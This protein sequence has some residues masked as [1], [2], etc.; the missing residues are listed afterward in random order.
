MKN[1]EAQID[2]N[3][4]VDNTENVLEEIR[5]LTH[6]KIN[7]FEVVHK[8]ICEEKSTRFYINDK[9]CSRSQPEKT[10]IYLWL[11]TGFRD[12]H[13]CPIMI[14]LR[15]INGEYIG[16]YTG[17]IRSM[18]EGIRKRSTHNRHL[19]TE[20]L[21]Q[22]I[23]KYY[24]K[25]ERRINKFIQNENSYYVNCTN[26]GAAKGSLA[27]KIGSLGVV[28]EDVEEACA[29]EENIVAVEEA[30]SE[31]EKEITFGLLWDK[32]EDME[33][34]VAELLEIIANN[35][36][37]SSAKV[38][39]LQ[40]KN[41]EYKRAFVQMR[42]YADCQ[43]EE[44]STRRASKEA[45]N[46]DMVGHNLLRGNTHILVI[47]NSELDADTMKGIAKKDY[48]FDKKD[49][50][51]EL[52]YKKVVGA[53]FRVHN[54]DGYSAV[55]FENCPHKVKDLGHWSSIIEEFKQ[56]DIYPYSVDARCNSGELK[57]TKDSFR[58]ALNEITIYLRSDE[59]N[60]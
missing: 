56:S 45:E 27:D 32:I 43:E 25:A 58:R 48:G 44:I 23:R 4:I 41:E 13:D 28:F 22:F 18:A 34:Y 26:G 30:P 38:R 39:E 59:Y 19:I 53:S 57:V 46:A 42:Q 14:A 1:N 54:S 24:S 5:I 49:F 10:S 8:F 12:T 40:E 6:Q 55:I 11:D 37:S 52:D 47:G 60:K 3:I 51:F 20:N 36:K 35:E 17:T 50:E 2:S 16:H 33:K 21:E 31:L 9:M 15:K 7:S 29:T